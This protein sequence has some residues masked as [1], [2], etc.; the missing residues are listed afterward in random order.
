MNYNETSKA[1][2]ATFIRTF[3]FGVEDS[4]VSTAGLLSGLAVANAP[5]EIILTAGA[6]LICV[7]AFSM[8]TGSFLSEESA[9]KYLTKSD[10]GSRTPFFSSI[11]MF[12]SYFIAG[13]IPLAPYVFFDATVA[14]W[15]SIATSL[16]ALFVLGLV[17][18]RISETHILRGG[19]KMF[20]FGGIALLLGV[21]VGGF[22]NVS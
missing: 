18:A 10:E 19:L 1:T 3:V 6:V 5:R 11:I 7:E 13:F 22:F 16:L 15:I 9:E 12:F 8:A 4:L 20:I 17:G 21:A 14:F 2:L